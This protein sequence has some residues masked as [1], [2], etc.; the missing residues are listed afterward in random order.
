MGK[1]LLVVFISFIT[2]TS[3]LA[4][5]PEEDNSYFKEFVWG[6]NKNTNG[7]LIGG[8]FLRSSRNKKDKLYETFGLEILNVKHPKEQRY[9]SNQTGT[10]FIWGKQNYLYS[11]RL[12]YGYDK[13]LYQK[14]PQQGVQ[15]NFGVAAGPTIG[16]EA[17]YY[18]MTQ[19]GNTQQYNP[20]EITSLSQIAGPGRIFEGLGQSKIV[21]GLNAKAAVAFEFGAFRNNVTG[22]ELGVSA[23]QFTRQIVLVPTQGNRSFFT[24]AFITLFWGSRK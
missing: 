9:T 17:P 22:I 20:E 7:G 6:F 14:A 24:A 1:R 3:V 11:I 16:L 19:G 21:P 4:Q 10:S 5:S 12:Q 8:V 2:L 23:E 13:I 15:I 18:V